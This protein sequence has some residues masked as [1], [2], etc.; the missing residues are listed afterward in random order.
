MSYGAFL[1]LFT[2]HLLPSTP[3]LTLSLLGSTPSFLI[4]FVSPISGRLLD[5]KFHRYLVFSAFVL[6]LAG[7]IAMSF[8]CGDGLYGQGT[9]WAIYLTMLVTGVGQ[10]C[11]FTFSC[12]N[13][14]QWF[15]ERKF[16]AIGITSSGAAAGGIIYPLAFKFLVAQYAFPTAMRFFSIIIGGT[17][18][19]AWLF[20]IPNPAVPTRQITMFW[21]ASTWFDFSVFR[22][23]PFAA[24]SAAMAFVFLGFF[25]LP[26]D[27]TLWAQYK[28][29]GVA[30]DIP[31]G[32]GELSGDAGLRSFWFLVIINGCGMFGR[33]AASG[34][35]MRVRDPLRTH[36][37]SCVLAS[38]LTIVMWPL[39][40]NTAT[41]VA[42]C[43]L[44][45]IIGG[46]VVGLPASVVADIIPEERANSLGQWMGMQFMAC[47]PAALVGP[48]IGGELFKQF[49]VNAVGWWTGATLIG[50][51]GCM[52]VGDRW[53]RSVKREKCMAGQTER[54][55]SGV[56][57]QIMVSTGRMRERT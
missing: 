6:I 54:E 41:A 49:G 11:G 38:V 1:G 56:E 29:L 10:A 7:N 45:G 23:K 9:Y 39:A 4:L 42:F 28:N 52:A 44:F 32:D 12:P 46:G 50:A 26:F 16:L 20:G 18:L 55:A 27:I 8:T 34:I 2:T 25:A 15:P 14:A 43:V 30:E 40:A 22:N 13:A 35:A 48:V 37:V 36:I 24:H 19:L 5:A 57:M 3:P 31:G 17:M 51:V 53:F 47:A 33:I 21:R